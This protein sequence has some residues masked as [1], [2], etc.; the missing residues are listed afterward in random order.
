MKLRLQS[1]SIRLRL[2][3]AEV[4]KLAETGSVEEKI[5]FGTGSGDVL[6]YIVESSDD[7]AKTCA[8]L[9]NNCVRVQVP[10]KQVRQWAESDGIGIE[11]AVLL[12]ENGQLHVL[13]E[14]DFACLN[15]PEEQNV[16][17]FPHPLAGS[18]C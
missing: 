3:R 11:G 8:T 2:K 12:G 6:H 4:A 16:D 15:G 5:I 14:K 17:T 9:R 10:T 13:I 1:N 18:K 7:V